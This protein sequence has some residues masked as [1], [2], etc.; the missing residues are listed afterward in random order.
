[1]VIPRPAEPTTGLL[2]LYTP[3]H[4]GKALCF[5]HIPLPARHRGPGAHPP[6]TEGGEMEEEPG[7]ESTETKKSQSKHTS[8][9]DRASGSLEGQHVTQPPGGLWGELEPDATAPSQTTSC[10]VCPSAART[11]GT[12][13]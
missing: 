3:L 4:S 1:M 13:S 9:R 2:P 6:E 10:A 8:A 5:H 7:Q 11:A 12:S